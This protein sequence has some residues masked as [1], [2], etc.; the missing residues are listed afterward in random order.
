MPSPGCLSISSNAPWTEFRL[1]NTSLWNC[2]SSSFIRTTRFSLLLWHFSLWGQPVQSSHWFYGVFLPNLKDCSLVKCHKRI[3]IFQQGRNLSKYAIPALDTAFLSN[4]GVFV[5]IGFNFGSVNICMI[6]IDIKLAEYVAVNI[7]ENIL[8]AARQLVLDEVIDFGVTGCF[9]LIQK[10][11]KLIQPF[12]YTIFCRLYLPAQ[13]AF[14]LG[15]FLQ[16]F[17]LFISG[18]TSQLLQTYEYR[19]HREHSYKCHQQYVRCDPFYQ[20]LCHREK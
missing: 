14:F 20:I 9:L 2:I 1:F 18:N 4:P 3:D 13:P 12:L 10:P 15:T 17:Y 5:C 19:T 16:P 11:Q 7:V 8:Q 6:Q